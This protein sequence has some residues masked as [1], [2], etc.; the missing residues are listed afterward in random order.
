MSPQGTLITPPSMGREAQTEPIVGSAARGVTGLAGVQ[1]VSPPRM[2]LQ[3]RR[4]FLV[5]FVTR[6]FTDIKTEGL[7][8]LMRKAVLAFE[9]L[10]A[11]P[12]VLVARL[13]RPIVLIRFGGLPTAFLG[14]LALDMELLLCRKDAGLHGRRVFDMFCISQ[15]IANQQLTRMWKR[16]VHVSRFAR[17]AERVN[18]WLPGGGLN[19]IPF[20]GAVND[21]EALLPQTAS[22]L[23]FTPAE[24]REGYAALQQLGIPGDGAFVCLSARDPAY[25]VGRPRYADHQRRYRNSEIQTYLPA[26]EELARRGYA[27]VRMGAAVQRALQTGNPRIIDYATAARTDFLDVFLSAHCRF[28]VADTGGL[29]A[30]PMAFRR[31]VAVANFV[32]WELPGSWSPY[33]LFIP[34]TLWRQDTRRLMTVKDILQSG[35]GRW[36]YDAEYAAQGID[37]I[38]NTPEEIAALVREMDERLK[39]TW[40]TT[41]EDEE[42]QQRFLEQFRRHST[43]NP[44]IQAYRRIGAEFL[45]QHQELLA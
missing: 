9:A 11:V 8:T 17:A 13:I 5:R 39:G 34:K 37:I 41:E 3:D 27:V 1:S 44:D 24:Q 32:R 4:E 15:S 38:D 16:V 12:F 18:R 36:C 28:F 26:A 7:R 33:D 40:R 35:A 31:P 43:L 30:L 14:H 25:Y 21:V 20:P 45:R 19:R 22:H 29:V 10:A 6:Q 2:S 42:L 23:S